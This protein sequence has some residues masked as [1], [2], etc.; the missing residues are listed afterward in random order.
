H[1][2]MLERLEAASKRYEKAE[3]EL[4]DKAM[5]LESSINSSVGPQGYE[6]ILKLRHMSENGALKTAKDG[7]NAC[8]ESA[9]AFDEE[10]N[11]A[12]LIKALHAAIVASEQAVMA[13]R[14]IQ[15]T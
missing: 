13:S 10:E 4:N 5:S 15:D 11:V 6:R 12:D 9:R 2:S 7:I 14:E 1:T 8:I 3:G